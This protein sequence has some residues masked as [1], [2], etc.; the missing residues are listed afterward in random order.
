MKNV[1]DVMSLQQHV[2]T[3]KTQNMKPIDYRKS[4]KPGLVPL[5]IF[6]CA[7]KLKMKP[8]TAACAAIVYHRFFK[9]VKASDYDEFLIAA[10]SLY[11]AGKIKDDDTVKIRD[12]INVAYCTLNRDSAPLDL[13]DEYWAMRDA[14]V[15]AELLI[16]RTLSFD[17][18]IELAHKYLLYYMK[19]LQDWVGTDIWNSVP[20]A[21][22]A[23]SYLQ[24]FHHSPNILK[25]KPTH[26]AI[27][28][29]S[30]ALQTYG[31]QVPLTDES[32]EASMWYKPLVKDFT[33][34]KQWEIIE[35]VIEVYKHEAS[36][37]AN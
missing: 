27:G 6:E 1:L 33:R 2:E 16:T 35:D 34:E 14:I 11:L 18:N 20:I 26:V 15:Q 25:Y 5:Y 23:A 21:K 7:A 12:V 37:M 4:T 3:S 31:V 10:S 22:T 13:N 28:C 24:D 19:T 29:L 36:L 30:L 17:L 9:E 32:D 8:L